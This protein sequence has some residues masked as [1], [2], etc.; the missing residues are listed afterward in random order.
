MK[1]KY[2]LLPISLVVAAFV[3]CTELDLEPEGDI[4][5]PDQKEETITLNPSRLKSGVNA[6]FANFSQFAKI[7]PDYERHND[8]GYPAIMMLSESAG[9]DMVS[10]QNGY[11]WF[12]PGL[13][14]TDR[15]SSSFESQ[16]IWGTLY[17]QIYAA[18]N[19]I[20]IIDTDTEEPLLQY[21]LAQV[22]AV[23][24]FDYLVLAQ[25]YQF[26]YVGHESSP[27]VP[28]LLDTNR[29]AAAVDGCPRATVEDVY[30]Q[31]L[32]DLGTAIEFLEANPTSDLFSSVPDKRYVS[33]AVAYGIRARA[34]LAMHKYAEAA[35]DATKAIEES[36]ISPYTLAE[37]SKPAFSNINDA[38]S[39]MWGILISETDDVVETGICNF[40]SHMG[41]L[42]FGYACYSKGFRISKKLFNSISDTDVRKGWWLDADKNSKNLTS[43]QL[44]YAQQYYAYTQVKF[45]PYNNIV[46]TDVN[47]CDIP[48][49]RIEEMYLIK[50]E[51]EA[52][53]GKTADGKNTLVDF[54]VKYR[55]PSYT[56]EASAAEE[57]QEAVFFQRRIE[58]WGEGMAWFDIMR[59]NKDVDRR[60]AGFGTDLVFNIPAG[61]PIMLYRL[62]E[63]EIQA[64]VALSL[65]DNNPSASD[66]TPVADIKE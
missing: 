27:C 2:I 40:P 63:T 56:C 7:F 46:E 29:D 38:D 22:L 49:M 34:N 15:V 45:A 43:E 59:L 8:I 61:S 47:A 55:D 14:Y 26:N 53:S 41:S 21:Y 3:A 24:A 30:K 50:A 12:N 25:L 6:V 52:M 42:N 57:L 10:S 48:L 5:T 54:V 19:V 17:N 9:T 62:P 32:S 66:P 23:R 18:N 31:I 4:L 51:G 44:D 39:W 35:T 11:N 33:T 13:A 20:S 1:R 36:G 64:N 28:L 60:G 16:I 37:A 58:L 65:S